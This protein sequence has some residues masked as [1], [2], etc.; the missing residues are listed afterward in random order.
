MLI[1][2]TGS[3]LRS[4]ISVHELDH[5]ALSLVRD[6]AETMG[7]RRV[8][9]SVTVDFIVSLEART[10]ESRVQ[11]YDDKLSKLSIPAGMN[12]NVKNHPQTWIAALMAARKLGNDVP[13]DVEQA[14]QRI[15]AFKSGVPCNFDFE[16]QPWNRMIM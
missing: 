14:I 4:E 6:D 16:H 7:V 10:K 13:F 2:R 11:E 8:P 9:L 12:R 1:M 5:H 3:S 15:E